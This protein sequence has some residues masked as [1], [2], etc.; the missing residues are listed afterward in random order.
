M[1]RFSLTSHKLNHK[2]NHR[3]SRKSSR[4]ISHR[5]SRSPRGL[6]QRYSRHRSLRRKTP[7]HRYPKTL[8]PQ[9]PMSFIPR[10]INV[11]PESVVVPVNPRKSIL[12]QPARVAKWHG[13][14]K[15]NNGPV[16]ITVPTGYTRL[17][18]NALNKINVPS[19]YAYTNLE[20]LQEV[21]VSPKP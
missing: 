17:N 18:I 8:L 19:G 1:T 6:S 7:K 4:R 11:R 2:S 12:G 16:E 5:A 14:T 13:K 21:A 20:K 9:R 15:K 3:S 10:P